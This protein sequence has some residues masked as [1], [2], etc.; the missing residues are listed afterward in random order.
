M[1][2]LDIIFLGGLILWC[3]ADQL[4]F[5]GLKGR[6]QTVKFGRIDICLV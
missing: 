6:N 3:I 4:P 5:W 1:L 2:L